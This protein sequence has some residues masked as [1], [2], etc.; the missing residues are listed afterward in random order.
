MDWRHNRPFRIVL[1]LFIALVALAGVVPYFVS[2]D[3]VHSELQARIASDT[4]RMLDIRG[5]TR[6]VLLPRPALL[7]GEASLSEPDSREVFAR[8]ERAKIGLSVWPLVSRGE[9]VLRDLVLDKPQLSVLRREDGTLNF[10]DLFGHGGN[11][12]QLHFGIENLHFNAAELRISDEFL[13]STL[14]LSGLDLDLENL[15]DPRNGR[16]TAAGGV[17][18]GKEGEPADWQGL[19]KATAA[20]RYNKEERRLL[21]ADLI[22]DL[23]QSGQS[24]STLRIGDAKLAVTGNLIYGWQPFR[25]TGGELKLDSEMVRAGQNWKLGLDLPEIRVHETRLALNRLRLAATMQ[26]PN[27][28]FSSSVE[29]PTLSGVQQGLLRADSARIQVKVTSPEQNLSLAFSSPLELRQGV[30]MALTGYSLTGSYGNRSLPRGAIP[31]DLQ[32]EGLLDLRQETLHLASHGALDKSPIKAWFLME[33]FVSPRYRVDL[34]LARLDLSSYLPAVAANAMIV[35]QDQPFDLWWLDRLD[36]EGQV[37]IGE[38]V[39]QRLKINDLAFSLKAG[40]HKIVL[41]PLSAMLYEGRL[42]GRAEIDAGRSAPVFRLRQRLSGMNIN[43]LLAD[44]LATNRFE[45]RGFLDLDIA[46]V[47]GKISDLRRTAGGNVRVQLSKGAVR[48]LD[49]EAV[50]RAAASQIKGVN[51]QSGAQPA[52]LDARTRFSELNASLSLKHGV[53]SNS[54]LAITAGV[55]KLA[56]GGAIDFGSGML[57]YTLRA[58]TNPKVPELAN[59]SGLTLPIHL[60]GSL[61]SPEYKVDYAS[62]REQLVQRQKAAA[63]AEARKKAALSSKPARKPAKSPAARKK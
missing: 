57:D 25:L 18:I 42:T 48:G 3:M 20:M 26:S 5:G 6:F 46:A 12:K 7:I 51:G 44:V 24:A 21:V 60:F 4:R 50:L 28:N 35:D 43:P 2:L 54:D 17:V 22:L 31:F 27:G 8:F 16:L 63:E 49:V 62:L 58:S 23:K 38:L 40:E 47:G 29:V 19:L 15:A 11:E 36:A 13:G 52:N 33:D 45:G 32:G 14:A 9:I 10:E 41:D 1:L 30:Q 61:A 56:G 39:L 34:D 37:R 59:L 55:L 53:A